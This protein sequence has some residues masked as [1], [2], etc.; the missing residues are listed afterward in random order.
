MK[1]VTC[2]HLLPTTHLALV[3]PSNVIDYNA[4]RNPA[5]HSNHDNS[6]LAKC[7]PSAVS[8]VYGESA[9]DRAI[10]RTC[11]SDGGTSGGRNSLHIH[12]NAII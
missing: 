9:G 4:P 6:A 1:R 3:A 5:S 12:G 11:D 7:S 10:G 2:Q 8:L